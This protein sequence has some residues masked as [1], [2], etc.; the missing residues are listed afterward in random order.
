MSVIHNEVSRA[1][2]LSN[3][4]GVQRI[5]TGQHGSVNP[6]YNSTPTHT[7]SV[8]RVADHKN[9]EGIIQS[10]VAVAMDSPPTPSVH[11]RRMFRVTRP[12]PESHTSLPQ[13]STL[14]THPLQQQSPSPSQS[15]SPQ[16]P[17]RSMSPVRR[18]SPPPQRF[19]ARRRAQMVQSRGRNPNILTPPNRFGRL[20]K[21]R[22][23]GY[24]TDA[25]SH[26]PRTIALPKRN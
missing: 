25:S 5:N 7:S 22:Q 3:H 1:K 24:V 8:D 20:G 10:T 6:S 14:P 16:T 17:R 19:L 15:Q 2:N 4:S 9:T 26:P 13:S 11:K 21:R 23:S 12:P 18:Q